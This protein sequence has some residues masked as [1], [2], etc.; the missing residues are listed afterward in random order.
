MLDVLSA[1]ECARN[2]ANVIYFLL[3]IRAGSERNSVEVEIELE[4]CGKKENVMGR[5]EL[6]GCV[7]LC[8]VAEF[9]CISYSRFKC[10]NPFD[11]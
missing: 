3:S 7:G 2:F 5:T 10:L 11:V 9:G 1:N 8:M 6:S 4:N